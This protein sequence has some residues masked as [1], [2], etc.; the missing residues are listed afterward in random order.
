MMHPWLLEHQRSLSALL[1]QAR[2]PHAFI[3]SGHHG[4]GK[5][6]LAHWLIG[7]LACEHCVSEQDILSPCGQCKS[8][9]LLNGQGHPDHLVVDPSG[10]TI[11]VDQIR[12][13]I[14]FFE[15]TALLGQRQTAIIESADKMTES[16]ANALL[17]TLEEPTADSHIILLTS[18][19]DRLLPTIIS[20]CRHLELRATGGNLAHSLTNNKTDTFATLLETNSDDDSAL[21]NE[22]VIL[23]Y[24]FLAVPEER[25]K[26]LTFMQE[27]A[28]SL[29]WCERLTADLMRFNY[30]WL[31]INQNTAIDQQI[32]ARLQHLSHDDIW[33]L[34]LLIGTCKKQTLTITQVNKNFQIEKLLA[35][36]THHLIQAYAVD[37]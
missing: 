13:V 20:R 31:K 30:G 27:Q 24:H 29:D 8:C 25:S 33:Q 18:D 19:I 7:V 3:I 6:T 22:F 11:G 9:L 23:F 4:T 2:M 36:I 32:L 28:K 15:K 21:F 10:N 34:Q 17:K 16:A 5:L 37:R 12:K 14:T 26:I 1:L 35:E